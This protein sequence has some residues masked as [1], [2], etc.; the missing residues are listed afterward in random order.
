[1]FKPRRRY[2]TQSETALVPWKRGGLFDPFSLQQVPALVPPHD[3]EACSDREAQQR[4]E[5]IP[6]SNAIDVVGARP[7][8]Q[9]A[10]DMV[11][12]QQQVENGSVDVPG[13][14]D[15]PG[16]SSLLATRRWLDIC[17]DEPSAQPAGRDVLH[18]RWRSIV[19]RIRDRRQIDFVGGMEVLQA[20]VS[21]A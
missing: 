16:R 9:I 8:D 11:A 19:Q 13:R 14:C 12:P 15:C 18:W 3:L 2:Y 4:N 1:M 6:E 21:T 20:L 10:R 7:A 17:V 5:W